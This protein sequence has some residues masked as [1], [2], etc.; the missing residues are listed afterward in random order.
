MYHGSNS[1]GTL[2]SELGNAMFNQDSL[3]TVIGLRLYSAATEGTDGIASPSFN[4]PSRT[5]ATTRSRSGD[6][7]MVIIPVIGRS[8]SKVFMFYKISCCLYAKLIFGTFHCSDSKSHN[9][10]GSFSAGRIFQF[11]LNVA[12]RS[13]CRKYV[14]SICPAAFA[15]QVCRTS[16]SLM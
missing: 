8:I 7:S 12:K 1:Y 16:L 14:I 9:H 15:C 3:M 10:H 4:A 2:N 11:K 5:I 6:R 13:N